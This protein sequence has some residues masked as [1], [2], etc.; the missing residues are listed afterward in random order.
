M[1]AVIAAALLGFAGAAVPV[2]SQT[3]ATVAQA[4]AVGQ[5]GEQ[6]NGYLGFA[7]SVSGPVRQQV[8]AVNI[9][10]RALYSNL[11]RQRGVAP[12]DVGIT[13][14]CELLGRV[15]PG[16]AYRLSDGQWRRRGRGEG[17]PIPDYCAP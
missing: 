14:G 6:F 12:D 10:R 8:N 7:S 17:P 4:R 11:A 15:A 5:V 16:E 13:A 9:K 3:N 2:A 1:R